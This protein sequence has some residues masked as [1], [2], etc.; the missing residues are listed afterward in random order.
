METKVSE[1]LI[2]YIKK[3]VKDDTYNVFDV[4]TAFGTY[5]NYAAFYI[6]PATQISDFSSL[7]KAE[8]NQDKTLKIFTY[9]DTLEVL[10][11]VDFHGDDCE[12]KMKQFRNSFYQDVFNE[13]FKGSDLSFRGFHSMPQNKNFIDADNKEKYSMTSTVKFQ[14]IERI[15]DSSPM[16]KSIKINVNIVKEI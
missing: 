6:L 9:K 12:L 7:E 13:L 15:E 3:V 11:R 10:V 2:S 1:F 5:P 16:V 8:V 14:I 4:K